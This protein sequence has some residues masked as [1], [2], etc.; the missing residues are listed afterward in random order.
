MCNSIDDASAV[1]DTTKLVGKP[2]LNRRSGKF[3]VKVKLPTVQGK[4]AARVRV[5]GSVKSATLFVVH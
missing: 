2:K 1:F 5:T 4:V 3:T